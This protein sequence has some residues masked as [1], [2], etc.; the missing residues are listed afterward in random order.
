MLKN[1]KIIKSPQ[2]YPK[3]DIKIGERDGW[4]VAIIE[5]AALSGNKGRKFIF[6]YRTLTQMKADMEATWAGNVY[7]LPAKSDLDVLKRA[8]VM[9]KDHMEGPAIRAIKAMESKDLEWRSPFP[10]AM[11]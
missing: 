9:L 5:G 7:Q 11:P 10:D 3:A 2:F 1:G 8:L 6:D 4:A